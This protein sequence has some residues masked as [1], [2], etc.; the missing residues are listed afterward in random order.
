MP[1]ALPPG[2]SF[3]QPTNAEDVAAQGLGFF[4][5]KGLTQNQAA[6]IVGNLKQESGLNPSEP[7][8]FLAQWLGARLAALN[9]FAAGKNTTASGNAEVQF[10]FIWHELTTTEKSTLAA[11]K[12][13]TTPAA[14]A[15]VFSQKYERPSKPELTK[16]IA[17]ANEA[18][19]QKPGSAPDPG[20]SGLT[21]AEG[22]VTGAVS[23]I[24]SV[25]E[26]IGNAVTSISEGLVGWAVKI[27]LLLAGVV[28]MIYGVM[29]AVRPR[30]RALSIPL[31]V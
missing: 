6:G 11:L 8:G 30:D 7:D 2:F 29:V 28:L 1:G 13:T 16:R 25:P 15:T 31:P 26:A 20:N 17:Y 27:P 3:K 21:A 24:T 12:K 14:A 10:E 18:A 23:S 19:K 5:S 4:I 9:S 22:A